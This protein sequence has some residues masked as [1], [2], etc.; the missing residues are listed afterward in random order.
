MGKME[1]EAGW[2]SYGLRLTVVTCNVFV[3]PLESLRLSVNGLGFRFNLLSRM[4]QELGW[5]YYEMRLTVVACTRFD[6]PL[7]PLRLS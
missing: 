3:S 5:H 6:S 2:H 4:K 7:Q 1:Q